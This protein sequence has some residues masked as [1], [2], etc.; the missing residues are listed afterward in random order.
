MNSL[1]YKYIYMY[2]YIYI[3]ISYI[4]IYIYIYIYTYVGFELGF[5]HWGTICALSKN[6]W[7]HFYF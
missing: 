1:R 2:I 6:F 7:G 3:Y 5:D 4:Y